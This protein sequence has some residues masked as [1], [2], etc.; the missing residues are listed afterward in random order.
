ML[1]PGLIELQKLRNECV[2]ALGYKDFFA[3]MASEY[4]MTTEQLAANID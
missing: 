4:G 3:Y 1:R 2:Q